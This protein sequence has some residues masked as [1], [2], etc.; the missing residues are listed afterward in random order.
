MLAKCHHIVTYL[1]GLCA[2]T[3]IELRQT[4]FLKSKGAIRI[5]QS[6]WYDGYVVGVLGYIDGYPVTAVL[7]CLKFHR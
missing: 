5:V 3:S 4:K 6:P 1:L 7:S 2:K